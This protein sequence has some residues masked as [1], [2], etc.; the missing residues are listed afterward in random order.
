MDSRGLCRSGEAPDPQTGVMDDSKCHGVLGAK[1]GA[2]ARAESV[3]N[4]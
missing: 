4:S 1:S 2:S 3:P